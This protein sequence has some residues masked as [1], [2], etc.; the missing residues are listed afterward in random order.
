MKK[1]IF[2]LLFS[3]I[4][5]H[6]KAQR[7]VILLIAD[8]LSPDYL[9]FYENHQD[10]AP[11][12]NIR[13]L[14]AKGVRFTNAWSNPL[15]SATRAGMLTG[16]YS[17]RTGVG[18]VVGGGG[19]VLNVNEMS[20]PKLL[21]IYKPNGI[22]TANIGKWH[23]Q[24]PMP[25]SNLNSP[26]VMG[27]DY[28]AGNFIGQLADYYN[29]TKVT[30]GVSTTVTTYA[31]TET[32]NDAITWIGSQ[33]NKPYFLWLAFNAP[34]TPFHLPPAGLHSYTNLSGTTQ[35]INMN[36]K[37]YF[38]ASIEALDTE[39]GRLFAYLEANKQLDSTDIVF[40]GDNGNARQTAQIANLDRA[41]GTIYEYG[42]TV[43]FI[44][45][46]PSVVNPGR[47]S[48]ALVQTTDLFATI[49]EL[50]GFENWQ[51]EIATDK[52]VDSKSILPL[53]KDQS[54]SIR[55]WAFTEVFTT[56]PGSVDG[57]TMRN[58][59]Y[60]LLQFDVDGHQEFYN[61][62]LDPLEVNNLLNGSLS[63]VETSHYTYLCGQLAMLVGS[64]SFCNPAVA[65]LETANND[66]EYVVSPNPF[67]TRIY[68][69]TT[70]NAALYELFSQLGQ[71][72]FVGK[73]I[74][75]QDFSKLPSGVY[76]LK[77][78]GAKTINLKLLKA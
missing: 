71:R 14:L 45:A 23:L 19:G 26:N 68:V 8:D 11:M 73:E 60:K 39:I 32:I 72:V 53:V 57:K 48:D 13:K 5:F 66:A 63:A 54:A 58:Q 9:G 56:V 77:I 18:A 41:K 2:S 7:N 36:P 22:A 49:V 52:P 59:T 10:T 76:F 47:V 15:C 62:E 12:P 46:G 75:R 50:L 61:L 40:I 37:S 44:I 64:G 55:P 27:Y 35:D 29:W 17:F 1:I 21:K 4:C 20:I 6:V 43:P 65:V 24:S 78:V 69:K 74:E 38:K 34:H 67:S 70:D 51:G 30:N 3:V 42:V 33:N 31:T 25:M 28:F 16:R